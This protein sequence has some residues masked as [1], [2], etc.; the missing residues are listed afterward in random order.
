M[1]GYTLTRRIR[2]NGKLKNLRV[3]LH[4]SLSGQF[5]VDMVKRAGA[6]DFLAKFDPDELAAAVL[7]F[8][9]RS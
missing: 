3:I 8:A 2:E 9:H 6:D 4:S 5:N 1:D 7:K